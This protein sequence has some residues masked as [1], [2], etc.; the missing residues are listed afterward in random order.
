MKILNVVEEKEDGLCGNISKVNVFF[1]FVGKTLKEKFE[2][3]GRKGVSEK[4]I[5]QILN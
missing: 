5:Y 3:W 4:E 1:E 2:D